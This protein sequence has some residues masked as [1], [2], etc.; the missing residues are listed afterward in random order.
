[1]AMREWDPRFD[2]LDKKPALWHLAIITVFVLALALAALWFCGDTAL[3]TLDIFLACFYALVL[4]LLA[5]AFFRQLR[6]NPYS[7]NTIIYSGFAIFILF[8]LCAHAYTA[9]LGIINPEQMTSRRLL[10]TLLHSAKNYMRLTSPFLLLFSAALFLSN[11]SLIRHEGKRFVNV[12]GIILAFLLVAGNAAVLLADRLLGTER[13]VGAELLITLC[14]A[15]YLY[16][17][18][19]LIGTII[20]NAIVVRYEPRKDK[21]FLIVLGCGIRVDGTP[22]PILRGRLDRALR[23]AVE[24]EAENGR[25]LIFVVSGGQ[26]PDEPRSEADAMRDYLLS[27]GVPDERILVEDRSTDTAENM[28]FSKELIYAANPAGKIAYATTN[29]HVFRAGLKARRVKMRAQGMGAPTRWY[30]WPNAA[31]REFVGMLTEHRGKQALLL[32]G[33]VVTYTLLTLAAYRYL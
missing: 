13:S 5:V 26:G 12:L 6:Y 3:L 20:A 18:C 33:M 9:T 19:M 21:D 16:F 17:E 2:T 11:V 32:I 22:S 25:P 31:V 23:F 1:M 14:A 4:V 27:K 15:G 7:Y 28:R 29:Y 30:F 10:M 8:V 24:Q